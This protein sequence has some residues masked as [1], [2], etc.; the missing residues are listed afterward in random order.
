MVTYY[1]SKTGSKKSI[2]SKADFIVIASAETSEDIAS[3]DH[4]TLEGWQYS[5]ERHWKLC[6]NGHMVGNEAHTFTW[7]IDKEATASETGLKHEE[8]ICGAVRSENTV[9][10]KLSGKNSDT[11]APTGDSSDIYPY[12]ALL[13]LSAAA[14]CTALI[15]IRRNCSR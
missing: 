12:L 6:S 1:D 4:S 11:S 10:A 14:V 2:A 9:I 5:E 8:C 7:K 13:L 15:R 3:C